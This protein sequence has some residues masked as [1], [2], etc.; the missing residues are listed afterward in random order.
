MRLL[1]HVTCRK[2]GITSSQFDNK[3][4]TVEAPHHYH[5]IQLCLL[6]TVQDRYQ[7]V[8][9]PKDLIVRNYPIGSHCP[10]FYRHYIIC[11]H[12]YQNSHGISVQNDLFHGL[13]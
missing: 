1:T 4:L 3:Y 9:N 10:T 2:Q 8:V 7:L 5:H 13:H 12:G 11:K 6:L